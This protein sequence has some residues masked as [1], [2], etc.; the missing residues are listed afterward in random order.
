MTCENCKISKPFWSVHGKFRQE[1][2]IGAKSIP[3][4]NELIY[5]AVQGARLI[6]IGS[7][8]AALYHAI[9]NI[10]SPGNRRT[11]AEIQRNLIV[12][13]KKI[14]NN[15]MD[16][17]RDEIRLLQ[18]TPLDDPFVRTVISFDGAYQMRTGKSGGCFSR[19]A[20]LPPLALALRRS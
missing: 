8:K 16:T 5:G 6:G 3:K 11:F 12:T 10:P 4:R 2:Q 7:T 1:I 20:L 9:L 14:A 15:T 18:G 17:A 19:T 13:A